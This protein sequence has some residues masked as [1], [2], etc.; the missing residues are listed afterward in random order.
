MPFAQ[1]TTTRSQN[2][3]EKCPFN[4][5]S[6]RS[7]GAKPQDDLT[8]GDNRCAYTRICRLYTDYLKYNSAKSLILV[9][10]YRLSMRKAP[11]RLRR[12]N[13]KYFITAICVAQP[14][15][16]RVVRGNE[17]Q[18]C[19][20]AQTI[21]ADNPPLRPARHLPWKVPQHML[22]LLGH[23]YPGKL[24]YG[25]LDVLGARLVNDA[26]TRDMGAVRSR[27][28]CK[29]V[30][31]AL[32]YLV[33]S[34]TGPQALLVYIGYVGYVLR[35]VVLAAEPHG[36]REV[37]ASHGIDDRA[38]DCGSRLRVEPEERFIDY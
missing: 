35:N 5:R 32:H 3:S 28:V 38:R 36:H 14:S 7:A 24:D 17:C 12:V 22:A 6:D 19:S 18:Y 20:F 16:L 10:D 37:H 26:V 21:G 23:V 1:V 29:E 31:H 27:S 8:L 13:L 30:T 9:V 33:L 15:R 2:T 34:V 25:V 4:C 11:D